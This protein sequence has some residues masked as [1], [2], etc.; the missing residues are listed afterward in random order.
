M[1]LL[2][3]LEE[4]EKEPAYSNKN[5]FELGA[6]LRN[7]LPAIK[8][9]LRAA[10]LLEPALRDLL[11]S[12]EHEGECERYDDD[13]DNAC[14]LHVEASKARRRNAQHALDKLSEQD[15]ALEGANE[16]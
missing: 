12:G 15:S 6:L 4:L 5:A 10:E 3:Q 2:Q 13:P 9:A 11:K 8:Q 16:G 7:N 14:R 1:T